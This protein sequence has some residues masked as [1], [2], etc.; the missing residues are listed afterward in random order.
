LLLLEESVCSH[1]LGKSP[2]V[3]ETT[4]FIGASDDLLTTRPEITE[5]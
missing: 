5:G 4:D 3:G 2:A 1:Y